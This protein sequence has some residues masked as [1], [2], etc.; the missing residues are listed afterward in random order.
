[1]RMWALPMGVQTGGGSH[2]IMDQKFVVFAVN[3]L[4]AEHSLRTRNVL[5]DGIEVTQSIGS[6][7]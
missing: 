7:V 2:D 4:T 6:I 3:G 5:I 1:M